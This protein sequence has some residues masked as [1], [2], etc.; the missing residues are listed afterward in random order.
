LIPFLVLP[1]IGEVGVGTLA[2]GG[3]SVAVGFVIGSQLKSALKIAL[4]IVA[5]ALVA[6][7]LTASALSEVAG[8][9]GSVKPLAE[10]YLNSLNMTTAAITFA[11]G[12]SLGLY[13]G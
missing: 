8:L 2:L 7:L 1:F 11:I 6:G 9:I 5:V 12:F 4:V 3:V 13:K 10:Q